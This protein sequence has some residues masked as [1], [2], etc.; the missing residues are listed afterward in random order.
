VWQVLGKSAG[1][2][3]SGGN[4]IPVNVAALLQRVQRGIRPGCC[5]HM[6]YWTRDRSMRKQGLFSIDLVGSVEVI[7]EAAFY[8]RLESGAGSSVLHCST[9]TSLVNSK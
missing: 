2:A 7:E 9:K 8:P 3:N 1:S 4:A 5:S 6:L